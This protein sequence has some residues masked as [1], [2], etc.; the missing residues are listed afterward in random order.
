MK[1][2]PM[3]VVV[4]AVASMSV[5][6]IAIAQN[7]EATSIQ[8][9]GALSTKTVGRTSSGLPVIDVSLR[10]AVSVKDLDLASSAGAAELQR[11]VSDAA[12]AACKEIAR[13]Y[14]AAT[15]SDA[16][17]VKTAAARAMVRARELLVAAQGEAPG[18]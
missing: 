11:R 8:A 4:G 1:V 9:N 18:R 14:P 12:E 13:Q 17:C 7:T 2:M 6:S 5:I 10:Y 15:P 16:E 3:R